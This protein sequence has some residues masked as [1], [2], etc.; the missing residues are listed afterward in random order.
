MTININTQRKD[1]MLK[2]YRQFHKNIDLV[3]DDGQQKYSIHIQSV[4]N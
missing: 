3:K 1:K 4:Y 2:N